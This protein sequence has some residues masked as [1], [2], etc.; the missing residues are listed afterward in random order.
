MAVHLSTLSSTGDRGTPTGNGSQYSSI[1]AWEAAAQGF[2][3]AGDQ[4]IL[5]C[6]SG[7][8][9]TGGWDANGILFEPVGVADWSNMTATDN[10]IIRNASGEGHGG[11]FDTG[12]RIDRS[13]AGV[14]LDI[15]IPYVTVEG[16][17]VFG[18]TN[19]SVA[20]LRFQATATN[21]LADSLIIRAGFG[22]SDTGVLLN[23]NGCVCRNSLGQWGRRLFASTAGEVTFENCSSIS[24]SNYGYY[25]STIQ[26]A[27]LNNCLSFG[28][29]TADY[30]GS[31][32]A[33]S[34]NNAAE[35][36]S[37]PG[38]NSQTGL[39]SADFTNN[40]INNWQPAP[41]GK[42]DGTGKDLS[43]NFTDDITGGERAAWDIGCFAVA[44]ASGG[45]GVDPNDLSQSQTLDNVTLTLKY[46]QNPDDLSQSQT[47]DNV[48]L[49]QEGSLSVESLTSGQTIDNVTTTLLYVQ[50]PDDLA[51]GQTID[52]VTLT[53][54]TGIAVADL[55]Q[56]QL[57]DPVI[58]RQEGI[59]I[60]LPISQG[61]G[62]SSVNLSSAG[63]V[64]ILDALQGQTITSVTVTPHYTVSAEDLASGQFI[65]NITLSSGDVLAIL[66]INQL[67]GIDN[68]ELTQ[69]GTIQVDDLQQQNLIDVVFFGGLIIGALDGEVTIYPYIAGDPVIYH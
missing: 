37:A 69:A 2:H 61:Q 57:I 8:T 24:S 33:G 63:Q 26:I 50:T 36:G 44:Y 1:Q 39:T 34:S 15:A 43:A 16:I 7:T 65:S 22:S 52:N 49:A 13:N 47:I 19:G 29:A 5:E 58:L 18:G 54:F 30:N 17:S 12:F 67:Q 9:E 31:W 66:D 68:V 21:G 6:Y 62:I 4:T 60:P 14:T 3:Q 59:I 11:V 28:A 48:T 41:G 20:A 46:L 64:A 56:S 42:L 45:A 27:V 53:E 38:S 25:T 51:S 40:G 35:G 55:I 23:A 32:N 10:L